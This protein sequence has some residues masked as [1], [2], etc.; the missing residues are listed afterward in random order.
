M[1][2]VND[3]TY[4]SNDATDNSDIEVLY[5]VAN[6]VIGII[7]SFITTVLAITY[8]KYKQHKVKEDIL[9]IERT[10]MSFEYSAFIIL[11]S[12]L[13]TTGQSKTAH[14]WAQ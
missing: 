3:S 13:L 6:N 14:M 1:K 11:L 12:L 4:T 9:L 7:T 5:V 10:I 2:S 8:I